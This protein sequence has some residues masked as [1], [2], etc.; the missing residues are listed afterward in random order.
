MQ[1]LIYTLSDNDLKREFFFD[2]TRILEFIYNIWEILI[3]KDNTVE[4]KNFSVASFNCAWK[5][6]IEL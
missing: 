6:I 2:V 4:L 5:I 1:P 3:H